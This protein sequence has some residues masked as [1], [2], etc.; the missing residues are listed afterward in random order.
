MM[1]LLDA[2]KIE[3][4]PGYLISPEGEVI[5]LERRIP[6]SIG[7]GFRKV[8]SRILKLGLGTHGYYGV[9]LFN[10]GRT[11]KTVHRL[12]AE[13]FI[14]NPNNLPDINHKD[15]NK[16]NNNVNNLEWMTR[17]ENMLH[18]FKGKNDGLTRT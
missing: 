11:T 16:L 7:K 5:S 12:V 10:D 17:S 8:K 4:F 2:R 14:P 3:G 9:V 6:N 15:G 1:G 18:Y 13:A